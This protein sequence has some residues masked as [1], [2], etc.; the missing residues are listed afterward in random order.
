MKKSHILLAILLLLL[1][2]IES[3]VKGDF[4][5]FVNASRDLLQGENIYQNKYHEW[6]HYYYDVLFALVISPLQFIPIYWANFIWLLFNIYFTY[7]IWQ[8][9]IYYLPIE[10]FSKIQKNILAVVSF[11][12]IFTLWHK[13]IHLTQ[14]TIF[15]LYLCLEGVYRIQNKKPIIGSILI[16]IGISV[17]IL[18][19]ILIPYLLYRGYYKAT[20]YIIIATIL[21]LLFPALIIGYDHHIFLLQERWKLINPLNKEHILDTS[22]RSF[23]SLTTL[24]STLFVEHAGNSH[25]LE[26]KR[27]IANVNIDTLKLIINAVRLCFVIGTLYFIRALP[28][29]KTNNKLQLFYELS[30]ILLVIPLIFPHQQH[31][32]FFFIF[33]AIIYLTFYYISIYVDDIQSKMNSIKMIALITLILVIYLLLNSHFLIG[34]FRNIFDHYKTLTYGAILIIP[35]LAYAKPSKINELISKKGI[36]NT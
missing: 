2:F 16:G 4:E 6:Y 24:L 32:A 15:I 35:L 21:I 19:I 7:R 22:E 36:T 12:F 26:L 5:I 8:I 10:N 23:H 18:P 27:N 20:I 29:K 25:S 30:Y 13:N 9:M 17:K 33:P 3:K 1:L 11:T 28:F 31:Y 14:M 34:A